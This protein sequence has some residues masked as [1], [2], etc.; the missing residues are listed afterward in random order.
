M[1]NDGRIEDELQPEEPL[2]LT[3]EVQSAPIVPPT[4]SNALYLNLQEHP[5]QQVQSVLPVAR[6]LYPAAS[7]EELRELV[8]DALTRTIFGE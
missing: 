5:E 1:N 8:L 6:A 3:E 4:E 2:A 7:Q